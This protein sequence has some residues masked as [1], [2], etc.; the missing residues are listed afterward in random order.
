MLIFPAYFNK[1]NRAGSIRKHLDF[2]VTRQSSSLDCTI[3][4]K[5]AFIRFRL[6]DVKAHK[7]D[8][9]HSVLCFISYNTYFGVLYH[10]YTITRIIA[11]AS[12]L[13]WDQKSMWELLIQTTCGF[14]FSSTFHIIVCS[15]LS[16][17][18]I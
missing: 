4:I 6:R 16:M 3:M 7:E 11:W 17:H 8:N 5:P 9:S 12:G 14:N 15:F 13:Q 1:S 10:T 2:D 18:K